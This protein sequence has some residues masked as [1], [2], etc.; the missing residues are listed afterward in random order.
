[1]SI[2]KP[3]LARDN[4]LSRTTLRVGA[5]LSGPTLAAVIHALQRVPGVLT[6]EVDADRAQAFVA[7]DAAVPI[8]S[9]VTAVRQ[10]GSTA[11]AVV[12]V[13]V[14]VAPA[15]PAGAPQ[16]M[17]RQPLLTVVGLAAV[18]AIIV[19]DSLLASTPEKRWFFIV[20]VVAL[21]AFVLLRATLTRRS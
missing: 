14:A 18:L 2:D 7:H 10:A 20:P 5:G 16:T 9:L 13:N 11:R 21:W 12:A 15:E 17:R 4:G 19:I 6:V 8:T 1:M 3:F